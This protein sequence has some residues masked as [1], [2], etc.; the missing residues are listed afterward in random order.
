MAA[1]LS[2]SVLDVTSL[3]ITSLIHVVHHL[4]SLTPS[5]MAIYSASSEDRATHFCFFEIHFI[6]SPLNK[7]I[8][9]EVDLR[10]I[11][12][13]PQLASEYTVILGMALP[14]RRPNSN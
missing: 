7:T 8:P 1:S 11:W 14:D 3:P 5:L 4:A 10:S 9:P 12:S 2:H 6:I 13:L